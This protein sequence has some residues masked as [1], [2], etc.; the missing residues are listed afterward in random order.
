MGLIFIAICLFMDA[1]A[2]KDNFIAKFFLIPHDNY[3][4]LLD[5]I[6]KDEC[7]ERKLLYFVN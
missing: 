3:L 4:A 2:G 7:A 6:T 1:A 5:F